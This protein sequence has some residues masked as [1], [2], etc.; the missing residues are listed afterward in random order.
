MTRRRPAP[1]SASAREATKIHAL[2]FTHAPACSIR[3]G[4]S[5]APHSWPLEKL[6]GDCLKGRRFRQ[7]GQYAMVVPLDAVRDANDHAVSLPRYP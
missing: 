5:I 2:A 3:M 6:F 1:G 4:F 7:C